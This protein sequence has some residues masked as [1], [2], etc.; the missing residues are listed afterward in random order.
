MLRGGA[1]ILHHTH[2]LATTTFLKCYHMRNWSTPNVPG[3]Q[4]WWCLRFNTDLN[5]VSRETEPGLVGLHL[6]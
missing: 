4:S 6:R 3:C 2:A 5:S 1:T